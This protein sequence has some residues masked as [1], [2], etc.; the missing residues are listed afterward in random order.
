MSSQ[1]TQGSTT[2]TVQF[3]LARNID[4]AAQDIQ[5]A[6]AKAGG[7]LPPNMPHPPSYQKVNPAEQ[8]VL[9]LALTSDTLPL[10]TVDEYAETCWRSAFPWPAACRACRFTARRNMRCGCSWIPMSWPRAVSASTK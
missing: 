3:T 6:I 10:Y 4:A 2:I 5:A 7:L 8:P 9:Y 1:N